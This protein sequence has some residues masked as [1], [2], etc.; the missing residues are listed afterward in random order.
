MKSAK[1]WFLMCAIAILAMLSGFY[2]ATLR[3]HHVLPRALID[4]KGEVIACFGAGTFIFA[5]RCSG[6]VNYEVY[7]PFQDGAIEWRTGTGEARTDERAENCMA[8]IFVQRVP[9]TEKTTKDTR[10]VRQLSNSDPAL[11]RAAYSVTT[12]GQKDEAEV[13]AAFA[14]DLDGTGD[15]KIIFSVNDV[16]KALAKFETENEPAKYTIAAGVF[17]LGWSLAPFFYF[18]SDLYKGG[19]DVI[20]NVQL[21][22][23]ARFDPS[24]NELAVVADTGSMFSRRRNLIRFYNNSLQSIEATDKTCS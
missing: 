8:N 7:Y 24:S 21:L 2:Y 16:E 10:K 13:Q 6:T 22:G 11:R 9:T 19:T 4:E 15:E 17:K 1:S 12:G 3:P 14:V 23:L 20:G 5:D 18:Q